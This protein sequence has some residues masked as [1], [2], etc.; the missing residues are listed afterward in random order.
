MGV[1]VEE[2]M[3]KIMHT[4]VKK[5]RTYVRTPFTPIVKLCLPVY[6]PYSWSGGYWHLDTEHVTGK[7]W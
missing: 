5:R 6:L 3:S 7:I 2:R 1:R 4:P